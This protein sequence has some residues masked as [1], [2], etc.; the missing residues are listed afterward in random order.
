VS[1]EIKAPIA[2]GSHVRHPHSPAMLAVVITQFGVG[3]LAGVL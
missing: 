1:A 3:L 2:R